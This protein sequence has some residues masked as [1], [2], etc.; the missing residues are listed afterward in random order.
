MMMKNANKQ[1]SLQKTLDNV[2]QLGGKRL[3]APP[4][5]ATNK[6]GIDLY[7]AAQRY[8]ALLIA[9]SSTG[10]VPQVEL[11]GFSKT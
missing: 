6:P 11:W 1:S 9:A 4:V 5:G 8:R 3:A 10:V 7:A 2:S